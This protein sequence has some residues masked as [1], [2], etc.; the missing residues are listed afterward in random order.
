MTPDQLSSLSSEE[1]AVLLN[2]PALAPPQGVIPNFENPP[3]R[4]AAAQAVNCLGLVISSAVLLL[5]AYAR[6]CCMKRI[7]I[8]DFLALAA[9]GTYLG[10][11]YC[12]YDV[13]DISGLFVHQWDV[14]LGDLP[15]ILKAFHVGSN[16]CAVT[17]LLI[18]TAIL[19]EWQRVFVPRGVKNAFFWTCNIVL[20]IHV[21][22]HSAWILSEN[23][24]CSPYHKIW[25]KL[26]PGGHCINL[27]AIYLPAAAINLV[28]DIVIF[29][30]P[31]KVIWDLQLPKK[32]RLGVSLIFTIGLVACISAAFRL[33]ETVKFYWAEDTVYTF[34]GMYLAVLGEMTCLFLVF[35]VPALPIAFRDKTPFAGLLKSVKTWSRLSTK[36]SNSINSSW[37]GEHSPVWDGSSS[38]R[39]SSDQGM[40]L[41]QYP[42]AGGRTTEIT[43]GRPKEGTGLDLGIMRTTQFT[44]EISTAEDL[45]HRG[46]RVGFDTSRG[47]WDKV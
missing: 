46:S 21:L 7:Q 31:Q 38:Y 25:D 32:N 23:L 24:S 5:R 4:D 37:P 45:G 26:S 18:K 9:Y 27:K 34:A 22:Y 16:L 33:A 10:C 28:T 20:C 43:G 36:R 12:S 40:I 44:A 8:E 1:Q 2:G 41:M 17:L 42:S 15:A 39:K 6:L 11:V 3:N 13:L 47:P 29:I 35:C 30:L 19:L 14:R